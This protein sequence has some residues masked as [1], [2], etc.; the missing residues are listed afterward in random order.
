MQQLRFAS[1]ERN[2]A[3]S[4]IASDKK[5]ER[6]S[7]E[8]RSIVKASEVLRCLAVTNAAAGVRFTELQEMTSLSKG[9]LHRIIQTLI[10][11]GFIEQDRSTRL[12]FLGVEFLAL[13]AHSANRR[14]I[15]SLARGSLVTLAKLS[16][17]TVYL[18][19]RSGAD[20]V[21][22]DSEE[23]NYPIKVLTLTVGM[24][25][26]L[27]VGAGGLMLLSALPDNEVEGVI[28]RNAQ[29]MKDYPS[30]SPDSLR[31]LVQETRR[32]GYALNDGQILQGMC[33]VSVGI[34]GPRKEMLAALTISATTARMV[35]TRR[36]TLVNWLK[37]E[38]QKVSAM[39]SGK[40]DST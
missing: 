30:Y 37:K 20:L 36:T 23:G 1:Q 25:R 22:V 39:T 4:A 31:R 7:G 3:L 24:R 9:T 19:I 15:Q 16:G 2:G 5:T 26:P 6:R 38:A 11:Q 12:Y 27:G 33:A 35:P 21:C 10:S 18:A 29:R 8:V 13:G 32:R 17:D 34:Y 14:D 28:R 40:G